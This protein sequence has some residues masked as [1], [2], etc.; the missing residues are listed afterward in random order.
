[1]TKPIL[2]LLRFLQ[3]RLLPGLGLL[4]ILL[5]ALLSAARLVLPLFDD[6]A[7]DWVEQ[8]AFGKGIDL[9]VEGLAL[10]WS[11]L[12]PRLSLRNATLFSAAGDIPFRV[13]RLSLGLDLPRSLSS[14]RL[15]LGNLEIEGVRLQVLRDADGRWQLRGLGSAA[16][17]SGGTQWPDWMG[18]A[19]RVQLVGSRLCLHDERSGLDLRIDD[20][21]AL[22]ELGQAEQRLALRLNLPENLGGR[23]EVRARSKGGL[24]G[25]AQPSGE[26]WLQSSSLKLAGWGAMLSAMPQ[27]GLPPPIL[28]LTD[29]PRFE[30]GD[31]RGQV[32]MKLQEGALID[33]RASLD[34]ADWRISSIQAMLAGEREV[35]LQSRLDLHL[36]HHE[37]DWLLDIEATPRGTREGP[38]RFSLHRQGKDLAMAAERIDLDL[39]RPWLVITPILP[40]ELRQG[41]IHHRPIGSILDL[42]M[43]MVLDDASPHVRGKAR[44]QS[45]GWQGQGYLPD[46]RG[47]SGEAWMDGEAALLDLDSPG[48]SADV[49]DRLRETLSFDQ[50][51]GHVALFWA[52]D[53][54]VSA[55]DLHLANRDL[56]LDLDLRLDLPSS[57][58][59]LARIHGRLHDVKAGR[60]PA[61]LPVQE[62]SDEAVLW[63][64]QALPHGGGHVPEGR[65]TLV[66][67]LN[68]FPYYDDR[69]DSLFEVRF[70]FQ[71]LKLDF[72]PGW[73][74]A[75]GLHGELAFIN[76]GFHGR[77]DGGSIKGVPLRQ[78]QL[79]MD[80]FDHPRLDLR[81]A[82]DGKVE[83]MLDVLKS[84]P[85]I[86]DRED[87]DQVKISGPAALLVQAGV[88]LD[89]EDRLPSEA[90]GW[91]DLHGAR[92]EAFE[93]RFD[94]IHGTL[95]FVD[96]ILDAKDL[97]AR[98]RDRDARI[99]IATE[100]HDTSRA[101][102]IDMDTQTQA[103]DW[104]D[105]GSSWS[106]RL[107]GTF[108]LHASLKIAPPEA[109]GRAV[110]LDLGSELEGLTIDLPPPYGKPAEA[111]RPTE[112]TLN[113]RAARL[114][115]LR[116]T[117]PGLLD[118]RL[119]MDGW[120]LVGAQVRLGEGE[121]SAPDGDARIAMVGHLPEFDLATWLKVL[122]DPQAE[123][124]EL[125]S[126]IEVSA[127]VDRLH[128]LGGRWEEM[129][130]HGL[131]DPS[132]WRFDLDSPRLAG[133][134]K[135]PHAPTPATPLSIDLT[136]LVMQDEDAGPEQEPPPADPGDIPP[137]NVNIADLLYGDI[138]LKDV[139]LRGVP[140]PRGLL[141]QDLRADTGHLSLRGEG[142]WMRVDGTAHQQTRLKLRLASENVGEAL[143]ELGFRQALRKGRLEDTQLTLQWPDAPDRFDWATL[144]GE[145]QLSVL[146][147]TIENVEPGAG[148]VLGLLSIAELPRRLMLDFGDVFGEGL[149]FDRINSKLGFRE[150]LML[151]EAMELSGPSA[152]VI[153][154]GHADMLNKTLHYDMVVVPSLGNVL[155]IIGTVAGGPLVGG[156]VFLVQ[157]LFDRLGGEKSGFNYRVTG[158]WDEPKVE[159]AETL[160]AT[161]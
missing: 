33:A 111:R 29:L 38:Q 141:L 67:D 159:R 68:H 137:L 83:S 73:K 99:E 87:F 126:R 42:R 39:L 106:K 52:N 154:R 150:G 107:A 155:P 109:T 80:D 32:W 157:K 59:T 16:V 97:R 139:H 124:G 13:S 31:L 145:G 9:S 6:K 14:G 121:A 69:E 55:P 104:L 88:R 70:G 66:G 146:A 79:G 134:V 75:E 119:R 90:E 82:L 86:H 81:L 151:T 61:Y 23:L 15:Q 120:R 5:A 148:R 10:D 51:R 144:R 133:R 50:A 95:H 40:P 45:L 78:G 118:A 41:L 153:M 147:G 132:A 129:Q 112:A 21:E 110:S 63:L 108:P 53:L 62:L 24:A 46:V 156:A 58:E 65:I 27:D 74:P 142:S 19:R 17:D 76:N 43:R 12:S 34:L 127:R 128:A 114:D 149:R 101:Y 18:Q 28:P 160:G 1:M 98:F 36:Q 22:F 102:R 96:D 103:N 143:K 84:S 56:A 105:A 72:A 2:A 57:G 11:G 130:V 71:N 94:H 77:I 26:I 123:G 136:R 152:Q 125:P 93:Q 48:L 4:V 117:Q 54:Q 7:R 138:R 91:L 100:L 44:F 116:L 49:H 25:L 113:W 115:M 131:R 122:D 140:Q 20:I 64:D 8:A 47:L 161:P 3:R 85:L 135:V 92:L 158:S 30:T 35:A 60:I 89:S 37:D